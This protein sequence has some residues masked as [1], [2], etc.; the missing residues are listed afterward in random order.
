[1]V[2]SLFEDYVVCRRLAP[3]IP[4]VPGT[5]DL[6]QT[7]V[8]FVIWKCHWAMRIGKKRDATHG[9]SDVTAAHPG[10]CCCRRFRSCESLRRSCS[11]A[12]GSLGHSE[13]SGWRPGRSRRST[14]AAL[15]RRHRQMNQKRLR[16]PDKQTTPWVVL[17]PPVWVWCWQWDPLH[18]WG[19][20]HLYWLT[21]STQ[22]PPFWQG[23]LAHSLMSADEE[24]NNHCSRLSCFHPENS[25]RH[26]VNLLPVFGTFELCKYTIIQYGNRDE[27]AGWL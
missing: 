5:W 4:L 9:V 11:A 6:L 8:A 22:V 20:M 15:H 25:E 13:V 27:G 2:I 19:Q 18:L 24:Q 7:A 16:W 17:H 12:P 23:L 1:M 3:Q 26:P 10:R 21:P 14:R